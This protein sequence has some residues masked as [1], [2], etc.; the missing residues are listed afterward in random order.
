MSR[1]IESELVVITREGSVVK[2]FIKDPT[3][4]ISSLKNYMPTLWKSLVNRFADKF[5]Q[6]YSE[7]KR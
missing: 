1:L 6:I 5:L 7:D 3:N 4:L 2:Y